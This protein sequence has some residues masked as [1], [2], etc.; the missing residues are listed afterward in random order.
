[1]L[2]LAVLAHETTALLTV[3]AGLAVQ[4]LALHWGLP[5]HEPAEHE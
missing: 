3:V 4:G 5:D 2:P 1:M